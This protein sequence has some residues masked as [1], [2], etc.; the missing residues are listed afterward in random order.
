MALVHSEYNVVIPEE[1]KSFPRMV[2]K[3]FEQ[4][5]DKVAIV[6][7]VSGRSY[8]FN[9][10]KIMISKCGSALLRRGFKSKDV[11]A[12]IL[13]NIPEFP[14]VLYGVI[15]IGGTATTLNPIYTVDELAYQLK[16]SGAAYIVTIP[17]L[18]EKVNNAAKKVGIK[19]VFVFGEAEGF[20]SFSNLVLSDDGSRFQIYDPVDW[21]DEVV[22]LPYSS[23]TTGLPKGVMLTHYNMIAHTSMATHVSFLS[24]P[25]SGGV[26]LG[27]LP[28]FHSYGLGVLLGLALYSGFKIVCVIGFEPESF[29]MAIQKYRIDTLCIVPPIA[30]FLAKHPL[31]EKF[32]LTCVENI[33]CGAAPLGRDLIIQ[34]KQRLP[35]TDII[36]RQGYGLTETS[37]SCMAS[38][39]DLVKPGSVGVLLPNLKAKVIDL[40][41]GAI[42]G[43]EQDGEICIAGPNVMKGYLNKP[44][45]TANTIDKD[46][47]LHTGDIGHYDK[48]GHFYI[49]DRVKELIKYKGFQVPP[50]ELE[51][52]LLSHPQISDAA[53]IGVPN[54]EAGELP[55]AFVV[56]RSN[57]SEKEVMDFVAKK[58]APH[59]KL[60]GGVEMVESIPKNASGKIMRRQLRDQERKKVA[61]QTKH[62][63]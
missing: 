1:V 40:K 29:L 27:L 59:K 18:V 49:V 36:I 50:A 12:I 56:T 17:Q 2:L 61:A 8:T 57:I 7:S 24:V 34:L 32:D 6:D 25:E 4:L 47:W 44:E 62:K 52:V 20:E 16:D 15:S 58:V 38:T 13:P 41:S 10:L 5:G 11:L 14:I 26:M 63:L 28:M 37:P 46:G 54:V 42:L 33:L 60:R 9:Q 31:V 3:R 35:R 53:V 19:E 48:D 30:L 22:F 21:K 51:S 45:A 23:G 55:K 43:P 39:P